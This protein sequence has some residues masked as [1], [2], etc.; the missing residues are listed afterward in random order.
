MFAK[1]AARISINYRSRR[2]VSELR[3]MLK[4]VFSGKAQKDAVELL[5]KCEK[6]INK[7]VK[8]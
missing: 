1:S 5:K 6:E 4:D 8:K 2:V 7:G 3:E